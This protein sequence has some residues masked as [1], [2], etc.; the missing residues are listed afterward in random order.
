MLNILDSALKHGFSEDELRRIWDT[1]PE[2][3][4]VR[5]R[6]AKQPP[7]YMMV[8]FTENGKPVELIAF[9]DGFDWWLFHALTPI[10]PG[11]RKE[12]VENGRLL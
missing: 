11:F 3:S 8:G 5:V 12:Y 9:T 10:T 6:H 4:V 2:E 1:V 7:H